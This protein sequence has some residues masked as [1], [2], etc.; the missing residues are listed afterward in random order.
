MSGF[1]R[2]CEFGFAALAIIAVA[3][4][5]AAMS[6]PKIA[7]HASVSVDAIV[8]PLGTP[9]PASFFTIKQLLDRTEGT[10]ASVA[11]DG[12]QSDE[13]FGLFEFRAPEGP[14]WVKWRGVKDALRT[15]EN[16]LSQCRVEPDQCGSPAARH[17][18]AL[19]DEARKQT[20]RARIDTVNNSINGAIRYTSDLEQHGVVDVWLSPLATLASRRGDCKDYA[21]AKY[22]ALRDAGVALEDMRLMLVRDQSIQQDHAVVAVRDEGRWLILDNRYSRLLEAAQARQFLPLFAIDREGVNLLTAPYA[23]LPSHET[24]TD[25]AIKTPTSDGLLRASM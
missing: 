24:H 19:V 5:A 8:P 15:E 4:P 13:P 3:S 21:I 16:V 10:P 11:P 18:L 20:G 1:N 7:H 22:F 6:K 23:G 2:V 9:G 25:V 17:F 14:L 12:N